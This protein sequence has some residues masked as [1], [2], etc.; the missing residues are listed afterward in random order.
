MS[1]KAF[2][3]G[4]YKDLTK[5]ENVR[6]KKSL[7]P[8]VFIDTLGAKLRVCMSLFAF[9]PLRSLVPG[10]SG[11]QLKLQNSSII[12]QINKYQPFL[13]QQAC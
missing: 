9:S 4:H 12:I 7:V 8:G 1:G 3:A 5:L 13:K 6:P 2:Q 11:K 10:Y